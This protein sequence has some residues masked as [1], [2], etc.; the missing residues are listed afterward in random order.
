MGERIKEMRLKLG[1]SQDDIAKRVGVTRGAI[2]RLETGTTSLTPQMSKA[3]CREFNVSEE[4]LNGGDCDM[5]IEISKAELAAKI[6][7]S[8]LADTDDEFI[9]NTFIALGQLTPAEWRVIRA[10]VDKIKEQP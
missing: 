5:F 3:L 7:A 8:A 2:S 9:L 4:W 1:F 10:F 6:V